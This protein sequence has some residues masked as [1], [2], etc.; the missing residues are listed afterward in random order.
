MKKG[1]LYSPKTSLKIEIIATL[2]MS[3]GNKN[4]YYVILKTLTSDQVSE[5]IQT[6][7]ILMKI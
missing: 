4:T 2:R 5:E 1:E 6:Y 7:M 3:R